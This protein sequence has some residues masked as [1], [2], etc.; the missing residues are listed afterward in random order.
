M[1]TVSNPYS[2]KN[3]DP[4]ILIKN[5]YLN[6][7]KYSGV[8]VNILTDQKLTYFLFI[9]SNKTNLE[10]GIWL[11]GELTFTEPVGGNEEP[12]E[13]KTNLANKLTTFQGN[14]LRQMLRA[15]KKKGDKGDPEHLV[16][17]MTN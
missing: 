4:Q 16:S 8:K 13:T 11:A 9:S 12:L 3:I 10:S 14:I 17:L 15:E 7:L 5:K 2:G 6:S 1:V